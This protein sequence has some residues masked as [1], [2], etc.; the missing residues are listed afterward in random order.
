MR[1]V[2]VAEDDLVVTDFERAA[3]AAG[4]HADLI[5]IH[6]GAELAATV[7]ENEVAVLEVDLAV[8]AGELVGVLLLDGE[9]VAGEG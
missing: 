5:A 9:I 3:D 8:V 1:A 4:V 2:A 6:P 7:A